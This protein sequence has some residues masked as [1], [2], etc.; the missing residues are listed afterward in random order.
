MTPAQAEVVSQTTSLDAFAALPLIESMQLSPAGRHLAVLRQDEGQSILITHTVAGEDP[1][2]L[3][4]TDNREK[5]I[6]WFIWV[7]DER[8]LVSIQSATSRNGTESESRLLAVNRD[9]TQK[10]DNLLEHE[11]F[12]PIL[13][14]TELPLVQDEVVGLYP[15]D[16]RH[17]LMELDLDRS[18]K[19]NVYKV[20]VYS[21]KRT[22]VEHNPGG[23][24]DA[25]SVLE[26]IADRDGQIRVGVG[27]S[28]SLLRIIVKPPGAVNW[29]EFAHYDMA[30]ETGPLPLGFDADPSW[31]YVR[32]LHRGRSAVFK[33][34]LLDASAERKLI[35][36]DPKADLLGELVYATASKRPIGV[37]YGRADRRVLFWDFDAQR[38]QARIDRALVDR[39]NIIE[40]SSHDGRLHIIKSGGIAHPPIYYLFDERDGT[41][42]K[43]GEPYPQ[44]T[45]TGLVEPKSVRVIA[46]DG[47]ELLATLAMPRQ[48]ATG[49]A[50]LIVFPHGE[51]GSRDSTGFNP[52]TQW[53]AAQGWAVL[54]VNFRNVI[55]FGE[56]FLRAGFQHWGLEL[57]D[58][59]TD[60][61]RWAI[62]QAIADVNRICVVGANYAGYAALMTT[63][64]NPELYRCV[65]AFGAVTDLVQLMSDSHWYLNRKDVSEVRM[66][67][68]WSDEDRLRD[69]SPIV[70]AKE[71]RNPLLLVHGAADKVVPVLQSR[72]LA[73]TLKTA[74]INSFRYVELPQ[75]DEALSLERDRTQVF[76][77]L[78]RF[79]QRYL[80]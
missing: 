22:V 17:V 3:I 37:R 29:Q 28:K 62:R 13:R 73:G 20:D 36:A 10:N 60:S 47:K 42:A 18:L 72:A 67:S 63:V 31:L 24:P 39:T 64:R 80:H 1:H 48:P 65:V 38:L 74:G 32:D 26:W 4:R 33:I 35:A 15:H 55:G 25:P 9:G 51:F 76:Q 54:Q 2:A 50:P 16:P 5:R 49:P 71:L 23:A 53:F 30:K 46:R 68:W 66:A 43:L 75:A 79:L 14:Q 7:S 59:L 19:P 27:Q 45:S 8:L 70:H 52:W 61:A 34:N 11:S 21:G 58:D 56:D 12:L 6:A 40:S 44:L 69:T 77:E 57:P 41:V 78:D